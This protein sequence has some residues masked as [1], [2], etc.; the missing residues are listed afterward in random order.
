MP[1]QSAIVYKSQPRFRVSRRTRLP[2]QKYPYKWTLVGLTAGCMTFW[3][4]AY[5]LFKVISG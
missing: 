3:V 1:V 2:A 5:G 4:V